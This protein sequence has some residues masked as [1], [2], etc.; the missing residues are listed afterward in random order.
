MIECLDPRDNAPWVC[1]KCVACK[2]QYMID[3]GIDGWSDYALAADNNAELRWWI[4]FSRQMVEYAKSM[5]EKNQELK[6]TIVEYGDHKFECNSIQGW[7]HDNPCD[8]GYPCD[9]EKKAYLKKKY[10]DEERKDFDRWM[11]KQNAYPD[12]T[13]LDGWGND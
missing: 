9:E 2:Y 8:C 10:E 7:G 3:M 4:D 12:G 6:E 1:G 5:A 13:P 11:M